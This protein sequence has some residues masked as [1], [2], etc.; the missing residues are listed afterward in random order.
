MARAR[1]AFDPFADVED[2]VPDPENV[3]P[4]A[5]SYVY[6][7]LYGRADLSIYVEERALLHERLQE[8]FEQALNEVFRSRDLM[9]WREAM[10]LLGR[11]PQFADSRIVAFANGLRAGMALSTDHVEEL[12]AD[13]ARLSSG[14]AIVALTMT[15]LIHCVAEQSLVLLDEPETAVRGL[16]VSRGRLVMGADSVR[17][18]ALS[19][20]ARRAG[21]R[22]RTPMRATR[23]ASAPPSHRRP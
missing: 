17:A 5:A 11:D 20:N 12:T 21:P 16:W 1:R 23:T 8:D 4:Q 15:R 3:A 18:M 6:V 9:A 22:P 2:L 13:F 14:H 10:L 19:T 7:G